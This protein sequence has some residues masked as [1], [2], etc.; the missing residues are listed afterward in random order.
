MDITPRF[1]IAALALI[2]S[3]SFASTYYVAT[4]ENGGD[5]GNSGSADAPF[6]TVAKAVDT[7][8]AEIAG[9]TAAD[10]TVILK[11]G[12]YGLAANLQI[13]NPIT[14]IGESGPEA[15][16]I[17]NQGKRVLISAAGAVLSG[18]TVKN[19]NGSWDM[20]ANIK[21]TAA[22]MVTNCYIVECQKCDVTWGG[23]I[24]AEAGL[25]THCLIARNAIASQRASAVSLDGNAAMEYCTITCNTNNNSQLGY[26]AWLKNANASIRNCTFFGNVDK[27]GLVNVTGTPVIRN[28]IF[29]DNFKTDGSLLSVCNNMSAITYS[30]LPSRFT[31]APNA[32]LVDLKG[33]GR[34]FDDPGLDLSDPALPLIYVSPCRGA[35]ENGVDMGAVPY[36]TEG[37]V[38]C[39]FTTD[40]R[41]GAAPLTVTFTAFIAGID[42]SSAVYS[43]DLDGDGVYE[44]TGTATPAKTY[45][46]NGTF[47]VS[48]RVT[49]A[50]GAVLA[51]SPV[52]ALNAVIV[53]PSVTYVK[54]DNATPEA[55]Y[56]TWEKAAT[57]PQPALDALADGGKAIVAD[58]LY[59]LTASVKLFRDIT[60]ES[61][62]GP[63]NAILRNTANDRCAVLASP[64]AVLSGL[65]LRNGQQQWSW[66][67]N[68]Y[69]TDGTVTNCWLTDAV[70]TTG[71]CGGQGIYM[72][73]GLLTHSLVARNQQPGQRAAGICV[74]NDA[75]VIRNCV[76]A[77][78]TNTATANGS[79]LLVLSGNPT[80]ESCTIA[81]NFG[82][83][84]GVNYN[85]A[86][87]N[88]IIWG[89][90]AAG[91][92]KN[93]ANGI[94]KF[95][96]CCTTPISGATA[97]NACIDGDPVFISGDPF[98]GIG[99]GSSCID[100]G[101]N[102]TWMA[103]ANDISGK[104]RLLNDIVDI[105]AMEYLPSSEL[106]C[107]FSAS[108]SSGAA[109][110]E[111][112]L[113]ATVNGA[114]PDETT[115]NW[116]F[117]TDGTIDISARGAA[118]VTNVYEAGFYS[119][120]LSITDN[121]GR[122]AD[123]TVSDAV[124]VMPSVCYVALGN[125]NAAAP[126][127]TW[128][129]AAADIPTAVA[130][131]NVGGTV[132]V[133]DGTY[134]N[135]STIILDKDVT[136]KSAN[137]PANCIVTGGGTVNG[138]KF[139]APATV[140]GFT[141]FECGQAW[142][143]GG[144]FYVDANGPRILNCVMK[145]CGKKNGV[146]N[147]N[148][149]RGSAVADYNNKPCVISNCVISGC[150]S[151]RA[152]GAAIEG[153]TNT[154]IFNCLFTG[155][156]C[157][158]ANGNASAVFKGTLMNCTVAG[159][160]NYGGAAVKGCT[161][162]NCILADNLKGSSGDTVNNIAATEKFTY[163]CL[164]PEENGLSD[165]ETK[166]IFIADPKFR[167]PAGGDFHLLTSSP[168]INAGLLGTW[169]VEDTDLDGE[170]RI[171][172]KGI[173]LGCYECHTSGGSLIIMR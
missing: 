75:A 129:T 28:C 78:N 100:T 67:G 144:A 3:A 50:G 124:L 112:V 111:V 159:N 91:V 166:H 39:N 80:I 55:P 155:N 146:F 71:G 60:L 126:F 17:D 56:D 31:A 158:A 76:I 25:I 114:D 132:I 14:L 164:W 43:W 29:K 22:G 103:G 104:P 24:H 66:G 97:A 94:A 125:P 152:E 142:N 20:G 135:T 54:A 41:D 134:V 149:M 40:V 15:T 148:N 113:T 102:Q 81:N 89:N 30:A 72:T 106:A 44:T 119:V 82:G 6:L 88:C 172:S 35:G 68:C 167:R 131:V 7:V 120:T 34:I 63:T 122:T 140:D 1:F 46:Q 161:L 143:D 33:N 13:S 74:K 79:G 57:T 162:T 65:S 168:C 160:R 87:R 128:E 133:G 77:C 163:T 127:A 139:T 42:T 19:G 8:D 47:P 156:E 73:G 115:F 26:T 52:S 23:G 105:G 53:R 61:Q 154:K 38:L 170:S 10:G 84:G 21:M 86:L 48:L 16:V 64:G 116:D 136:V 98:F 123:Y 11:A 137:G 150:M 27:V 151:Q 2:S 70:S 69:M 12:T 37:K 130:A 121:G 58:G 101:T 96:H 4:A 107:A 109:P 51:V 118:I 95:V 5:D 157:R 85:G 145:D 108:P 141:V 90:V 32:E 171:F 147:G 49:D 173:D 153:T 169:T 110:L 165:D 117:D 45:S 9:G 92:T 138:F 83:D 62:N 36:T 18:V 93:Y 99:L 59:E